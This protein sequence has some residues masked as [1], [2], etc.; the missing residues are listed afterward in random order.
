MGLGPRGRWAQAGRLTLEAPGVP[1]L[2][3][4]LPLSVDL[5][6]KLHQ[7]V[8]GAVPALRQV[9]AGRPPPD[10]EGLP[11]PRG[12]PR[13]LPAVAPPPGPGGRA[14]P[15]TS[16]KRRVRQASGRP[17]APPCACGARG[18]PRSSAPGP[19]A[20]GRPQGP[21]SA[22]RAGRALTHVSC[23]VLCCVTY[24]YEN[25]PLCPGR[26]FVSC[27]LKHLIHLSQ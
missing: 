24:C 4:L 6:K 26:G 7:A 15:P 14:A 27:V 8:P 21:C 2:H 20:A 18:P 12:L 3:P 11:D 22:S 25:K 23:W 17:A 1:S 9:P 19:C 13:H 5:V 10:V 16:V